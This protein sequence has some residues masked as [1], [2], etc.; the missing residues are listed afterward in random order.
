MLVTF[1]KGDEKIK[2]LRCDGKEIDSPEE[3]LLKFNQKKPHQKVRVG[4]PGEKYHR[5]L[6]EKLCEKF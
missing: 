1:A 3:K 6:L 4:D 2:V 5:D